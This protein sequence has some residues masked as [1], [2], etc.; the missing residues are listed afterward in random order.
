MAVESRVPVTHITFRIVEHVEVV[1][2]GVDTAKEGSRKSAN[3]ETVFHNWKG[4]PKPK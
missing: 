1:N 3:I 4:R 2:S